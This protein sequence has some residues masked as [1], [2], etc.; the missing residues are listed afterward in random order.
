M[1]QTASLLVLVILAIGLLNFCKKKDNPN[2]GTSP[3]ATTD[4]S[5]SASVSGIR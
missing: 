2:P 5:I 1:K 4:L 3:C